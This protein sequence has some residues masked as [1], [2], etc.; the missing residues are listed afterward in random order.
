VKVVY[1]FPDT[2]GKPGI[3]TTAF[4][5]VQGLARLGLD[6]TVYC[7]SAARVPHG[8]IDLFETMKVAGRRVPHRALGKFRAYRYHDMRTAKALSLRH[9]DADIVHCWPRATLHTADAAR[10]LGVPTAREVPNT[11]TAYAFAR[12]ELETQKL[13]LQPPRGHSHSFSPSILE[14]EEAEYATA[15]ALL[16]PSEFSKQTFVERD[17]PREKLV[18]HRYGYDPAA[19]QPPTEEPIE[20]RPLTALYMGSGEPRK[21]LHYA[22]KAW[23]DGGAA[24]VGQLIVCGNIEPSYGRLLAELLAHPSVEQRGFVSDPAVAMRASMLFL[25]PSIEEGSALVT[26][27]AQACGCV[28]LVSDAAGAR[29]EH[30]RHGFV[31]RAGDL[32]AL[33]EHVRMVARDRSLLT[34]LRRATLEHAR[35]LTWDDAAVELV[36]GYEQIVG[37]RRRSRRSRLSRES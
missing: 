33:T 3:G 16:V 6:V 28:L 15:D 24:E 20:S 35:H 19:F 8:V 36:E 11:H 34:K 14:L 22:L 25:L 4:Y 9:Q 31:H 29:C 18:V 17:V 1:S 13:G 30:G 5:Q 7:T 21:G 37:R 27:E 2:L 23:F 26:Y 10:V 12:T 32:D